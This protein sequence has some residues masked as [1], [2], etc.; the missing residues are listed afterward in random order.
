[1]DHFIQNYDHFI[2]FYIQGYAD[3]HHNFKCK[4]DSVKF[5]YPI[6]GIALWQAQLMKYTVVPLRRF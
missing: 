2:W 3:M 6:Y 1:M 4:K 5:H